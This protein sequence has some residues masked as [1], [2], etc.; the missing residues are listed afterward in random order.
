ME[1]LTPSK[2]QEYLRKKEIIVTEEMAA[3]VLKLLCLFAN[4]TIDHYLK[5]N[6]NES[7]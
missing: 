6:E 2:V 4:I 1:K 7:S 3:R 5:S